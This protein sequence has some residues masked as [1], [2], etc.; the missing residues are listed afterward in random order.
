MIAKMIAKM[1]DI[2]PESQGKSGSPIFIEK[3]LVLLHS[4]PV[5]E[6]TGSKLPHQFRV[7]YP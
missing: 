7:R 3:I 2:N 5:K 6:I 4:V 1:I